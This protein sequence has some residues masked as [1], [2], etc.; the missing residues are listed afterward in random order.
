VIKALKVGGLDMG[1]QSSRRRRLRSQTGWISSFVARAM[2]VT[3]AG[4][5]CAVWGSMAW[6]QEPP[7]A[8][9]PPATDAPAAP[10]EPAPPPPPAEAAPPPEEPAAAPPAADAPVADP[11]MS[12]PS[13]DLEVGDETQ[14]EEATAPGMDE[15]VVTVDRRRKNLQDYSGTAAAFSESQ[16][17]NLGVTN[18]TK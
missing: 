12:D 1:R 4:V 3:G 11:S 7:P 2:C 10:A 16:L 17:T 8:D 9:A 18:I 13:M 15:V 6:A 14:P 5:A